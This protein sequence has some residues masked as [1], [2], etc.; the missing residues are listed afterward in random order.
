MFFSS[1]RN[2]AGFW[3]RVTAFILDIAIILVLAV[4]INSI[5]KKHGN[6]YSDIMAVIY[7]IIVPIVWNGYTVGKRLLGI[8][9]ERLSGK[10]VSIITMILRYIGFAIYIA[11]FG[12]AFIISII[13]MI[14]R[15]DNRSLHDL[16]AGTC[17]NQ[18]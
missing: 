9:I 5:F 14:F 1:R 12:I 4:V 6:L 13:M 16:I 10:R 8:R 7:L 18:N 11:T 17:V 15:C 2:P 3:R